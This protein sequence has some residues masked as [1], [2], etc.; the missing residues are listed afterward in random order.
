M[1]IGVLR[2]V[3]NSSTASIDRLQYVFSTL[4][5]LLFKS[6][7]SARKSRKVDSPLIGIVQGHPDGFGFVLLEGNDDI[8]LD[9][10]QMAGVFPGDK[11]EVV[12]S[13]TDHRDRVHGRVLEVLE[14]NTSQLVGTY[15]REHGMGFV[16]PENRR[17]NIDISVPSKS[18]MGARSGEVVVVDIVEQPSEFTP[19]VGEITEVL[20]DA[21]APGMEVEIAIRSFDLPNAWSDEVI[22]EADN[23]G[24]HVSDSAKQSREDLTHLDFV[25]IDGAD[26]KDFDDAVY[27]EAIRGG[28]WKLWVAIADVSHYVKPGSPL[29]GAAHERG[30]SVYFPN[31]VVPMLPEVLSNG[32]CS[33]R[34]KVDRLAMVCEMNIKADGSIK[35]FKFREAVIRSKARLT[36]TRVAKILEERDHDETPERDKLGELTPGIDRLHAL[37]KV[38]FEKRQRRGAMDFDSAEVAFQFNE[39]RKIE[40]VVP[41]V[42]NDAHR[43]IEECMLC[44]NICAA[45]F[46]QKLKIPGLYR[47][48]LPPEAEKLEALRDYL[49]NLGLHLSASAVP[50]PQ[51]FKALMSRLGDRPDRS[52]IQTQILRSQQQAVYQPENKGHFGLAYPEYAHFTSPIRRYPDLLVHRAIRS[53]IHSKKRTKLVYRPKGMVIAEEKQYPY[54]GATMVELGTHC[55]ST[56]RRAEEASR[57]VIQWL[58]CEYL[59]DRV[60]ET[61]KAVVTA[62]APFGLFAELTDIHIDGLIHITT[63]PSDYYDFDPRAMCLVG[64][65][66]GRRFSLGNKVLVQIARVSLEERRVD[67][68]LANADGTTDT[69]RSKDKKPPRGGRK[70]ASGGKSFTDKRRDRSTARGKRKKIRNRKK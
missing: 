40:G 27:A 38:L 56:E 31:F 18:T 15:H 59:K 69:G 66:T 24:A 37:Y 49:N 28:G 58:K 19:A 62:V 33:L 53:I 67:F 46:L 63:L 65:D 52:I 7:R 64:R 10:Q 13:R 41:I 36:Y 34:P 6:S 1:S 8:Y 26:A 21:M 61:M 20:G 23:F 51:Q 60:G 16:R 4:S 70:H 25:T 29:D 9:N 2:P 3:V 47:V 45:Q 12:A 14:R 55:S 17:V 48:H 39:E 30:T 22:E 54:D 57:D 11:V 42:R 68:V 32:L 43:L 44:A 50:E 35:D 5:S